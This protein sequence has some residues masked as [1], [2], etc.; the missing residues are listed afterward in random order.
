VR[1]FSAAPGLTDCLRIS[2]GTPA[3]NDRLL[4]ALERL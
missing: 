4:T 2:M 3:Q 1:D